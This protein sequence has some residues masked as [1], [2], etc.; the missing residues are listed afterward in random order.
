MSHQLVLLATLFLPCTPFFLVA[1]T[2]VIPVQVL[3]E[4]L[5]ELSLFLFEL[6]LSLFLRIET[7]YHTC[8][9]L[10]HAVAIFISSMW[11]K[12]GKI[13]VGSEDGLSICETLSGQRDRRMR[14]RC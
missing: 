4:I 8:F 3:S 9:P 2:S 6:L 12:L 7:T 14:R 1:V 5:L 10:Y 11:N 13:S